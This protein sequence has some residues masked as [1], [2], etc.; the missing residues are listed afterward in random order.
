[1]DGEGKTER[2]NSVTATNLGEL[3]S[4]ILILCAGVCNLLLSAE[5]L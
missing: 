3:P 4:N 2:G 5:S 1:M